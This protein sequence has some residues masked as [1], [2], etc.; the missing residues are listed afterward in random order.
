MPRMVMTIK[1]TV[2]IITKIL[3]EKLERFPPDF[4]WCEVWIVDIRRQNGE[5]RP[6]VC[7]TPDTAKN[8]RSGAKMQPKYKWMERSFCMALATA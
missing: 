4:N 3:R 1:L 7:Q 2:M 8:S 5:R 6:K